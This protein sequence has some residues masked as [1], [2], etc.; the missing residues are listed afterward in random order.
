MNLFCMIV[1]GEIG[2][3]TPSVA[4][5]SQFGQHLALTAEANQFIH[6]S[7]VDDNSPW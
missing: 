2:N 3:L 5:I 4:C 7:E 1:S 6:L